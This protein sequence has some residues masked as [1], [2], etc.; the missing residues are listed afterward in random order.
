MENSPKSGFPWNFT[1]VVT[2]QGY[3]YVK[4]YKMKWDPVLKKSNG[5]CNAMWDV[6]SKTTGSR[7]RPNFQP[8][9]RNTPGMTGFG[10]RT[11][12]L[13]AKPNIDK[14]FLSLP[15]LYRNELVWISKT[16]LVGIH[17]QKRI[18][19]TDCSRRPFSLPF[20]VKAIETT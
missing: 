4:A 2:A 19:K 3:C 5:T 14:I 20:L 18:P 8:T 1:T 9:F 11:K 13:F 16:F 17:L 12:K 6:C 7:F 15:A 10:V